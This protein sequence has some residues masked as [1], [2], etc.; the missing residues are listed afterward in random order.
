MNGFAHRVRAEIDDARCLT[1]DIEKG[2]C[3]VSLAD[4]PHPHVVIDLD[5]TGSPL[6]PTQTKCDF[7]FFADPDLAMPIEIKGGTPNVARAARQLQ[8]G[9]DAAH[10]LA[11]RDSA[12]DFRPVL[13]SKSMRRQQQMEL[14]QTR[15]QFRGREEKIRRVPCGA[16]LTEA[17]R[18]T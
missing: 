4:A 14:R 11:P 13:V 6:G 8:A 9:A 1:D 3:G 17:L 2:R 10:R 18:N 16:P 12:I 15:V 5:E 7:L